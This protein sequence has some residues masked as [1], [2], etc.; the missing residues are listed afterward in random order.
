MVTL[1]DLAVGQTAEIHRINHSQ[2]AYRRRL[3]AFGILPGTSIQVER[4]APLGDPI[5][6]RVRGF[7]ISLRRAEAALL[8]IKPL[9][10]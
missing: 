2:D 5:E 4:I 8:E 3:L 9:P 6:V 1:A 10:L 7:S